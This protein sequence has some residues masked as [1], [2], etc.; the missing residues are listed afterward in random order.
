MDYIRGNSL[1]EKLRDEGKLS[2]AKAAEIMI[3]VARAVFY[4]NSV[5]GLIHRDLKPANIL[6]SESGKPF[7]T[8][9]GLGVYKETLLND[10]PLSGGTLEYMAP[11]QLPIEGQSSNFARTDIYGLGA[12]LY[13]LLS[14]Q[15]PFRPNGDRGTLALRVLEETPDSLRHADPSIPEAIDK[16]CLKCL[17]KSPERR[18]AT[19]EELADDLQSFLDSL[20]A[21]P[22]RRIAVAGI[23][24]ASMMLLLGAGFLLY[25]MNRL[26]KNLTEH[27][28]SLRQ[29]FLAFHPVQPTVVGLNPYRWVGFPRDTVQT[30]L[31]S[32]R[33]RIVVDQGRAASSPLHITRLFFCPRAMVRTREQ[34]RSG[35][36][37]VNLWV[38]GKAGPCADVVPRAGGP[39]DSFEPSKPLFDGVYC[40]H[41]GVLS[42]AEP[43]PERCCPFIVRGYG[44]PE[45]ENYSAKFGPNNVKLTVTELLQV[46]RTDDSLI[47]DGWRRA[48]RCRRAVPGSQVI[49][50]APNVGSTPGS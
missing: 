31:E 47:L 1:R 8:D 10:S 46:F 25:R 26:D 7:V 3:S 15:P 23:A 37:E 33:P 17:E 48:V 11:E 42:N 34:N 4:L 27:A 5:G 30:V 20:D 50:H 12:T 24:A 43:S 49:G 38:P 16:I 45:V 18:Y 6:I 35:N 41:T 39:D 19:A 21:S 28:A 32:K 14:G 9:L 13:A 36:M 29:E 22:K 44:V 40:I 2:V